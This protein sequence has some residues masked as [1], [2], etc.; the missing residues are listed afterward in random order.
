MSKTQI[1]TFLMGVASVVVGTY[2]VK[3][4]GVA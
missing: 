4:L 2:M 3:R 1:N